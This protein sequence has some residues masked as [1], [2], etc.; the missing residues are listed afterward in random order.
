MFWNAAGRMMQSPFLRDALE[1]FSTARARLWLANRLSV[2]L[3][4]N[5]RQQAELE[6]WEVQTARTVDRY[7]SS[8]SPQNSRR[9]SLL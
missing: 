9:T 3:E 2:T 6:D 4:E 1:D 7:L 8:N 5:L